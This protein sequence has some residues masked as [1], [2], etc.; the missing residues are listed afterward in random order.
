MKSSIYLN[1]RV[2]VMDWPEKTPASV[3]QSDARPSGE[4][5]VPQG[6]VTFFCGD[7]V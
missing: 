4:Q 7:R 5:E 3:A 2:F 1:R 6:P